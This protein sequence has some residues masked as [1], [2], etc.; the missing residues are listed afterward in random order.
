M[1]NLFLKYVSIGVI[2][3]LIHWTT[4]I[5]LT[6]LLHISQSTSNLLAFIAAV[7]FSFFANAKFTFN[8]KPT[9]YKYFY[10]VIFM[11]GMSYIF[12]HMADVH[13]IHPTVTLISYSVLSLF[14]GFLFSKIFIFN[15][16]K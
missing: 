10:F 1:I 9:R 5:I 13:N 14:V 4:F 15:G 2:N 3:T 12:G 6:Y 11:G 16:D 7:T 8:K